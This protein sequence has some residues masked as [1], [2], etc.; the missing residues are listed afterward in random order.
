MGG[1]KWTR[2]STVKISEL[3]AHAGLAIS[4]GTVGRLL[5]QMD[6]R[7]RVNHKQLGASCPE[8]DEQFC[9]IARLRGR[10]ERNGLPI[11]SVDT[12]KRE[13]IGNFKNP[14]TRW[15]QTPIEVNDHDFRTDSAGI[16]IPYGIYD[17][18]AVNRVAK[19]RIVKRVILRIGAD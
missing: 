12:K 11:I 9:H 8:R 4:P 15:D 13:L 14:G 6:Y 19:S 7:L 18:L 17:V 2:K 16:A 5:H 1:L 3:L 10:F